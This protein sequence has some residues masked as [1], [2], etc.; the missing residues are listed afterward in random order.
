MR[1][2][3]QLAPIKQLAN[4][5]SDLRRAE[6]CYVSPAL[7]FRHQRLTGWIIGTALLGSVALL[8]AQA[9]SQTATASVRPHTWWVEAGSWVS[10]PNEMLFENPLGRL[11]VLNT[12][13]PIDTKGHPFFEAIGA[14]GRACVTC[15][16]PANAMSVS[17]ASIRERWLL[18]GGRDPIF[19][20]IDGS[21]NPNLPQELASSHSLLLDRGLF[22]V[23]L[24]WPPTGVTPEFTIEVVRDPTGVNRDPE[25]GLRSA[26]P[27][28]SVF[29]RPRPAANLKYVTSP[30]G[31]FNVKLGVLM[32]KD[33]DTGLPSSM[34]IMADA[35]AASLS[36]QAQS[37]YHDHQAGKGSLTRQQL[38]RILGFENQV[39]VAQAWDARAGSLA[40]PNGPAALG[41]ANVARNAVHVLNSAKTPGFH[42]FDMWQQPPAAGDARAEF[43][44]SVARGNDIFI[45]RRFWVKDV[46]HINSIGLANP[47]KRSC[48]VCHNAQMSGMDLAPGWV[49]LGTT[50][51]PTWTESKV[52]SE[53]ADLPVFKLTCR[54]DARPHPFLGR[55]I[56]TSDPGRALIT[57]HCADIGAVTMQQFRG[58]AARAPYFS[59]GSAR[60]LRE[61]V[62]YY[63]RRFDMRLTGQEKQ[64]LVNFLGVL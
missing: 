11:G 23:G 35:R 3:Q 18:T 41:P 6:L 58:L 52:W 7:R 12:S 36:I 63:D 22:R 51:Y 40:E 24:P 55:V 8:G 26:R 33:P 17:V 49:D 37:A 9:D 2:D 16:Q 47:A 28:V 27:T 15:H 21:N 10:L 13:G 62:D 48:A 45:N 46:A 54:A 44:A 43:R 42:F 5:A 32:D 53:S 38:D 29:R 60:D 4:G 14:N 50:N 30:D 56:Y 20:A 39:Y 31:L 61:L 64:D 1:V 25:Y 57:G 34:N 59:N 19:A